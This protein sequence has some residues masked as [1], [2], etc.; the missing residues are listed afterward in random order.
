[1]TISSYPSMFSVYAQGSGS[2]IAGLK[3]LLQLAQLVWQLRLLSH[4]PGDEVTS[5]EASTPFL[6]IE[7]MLTIQSFVYSKEN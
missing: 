7:I 2:T 3:Q 6:P 5:C 1:M 4:L